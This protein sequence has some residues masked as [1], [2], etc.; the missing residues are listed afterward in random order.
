MA[1]FVITIP[2]AVVTRIRL[3]FGSNDPESGVRV[4]ATTIEVRAVLKNYLK[5]HVIEYE[6]GEAAKVKR[7][8]VGGETW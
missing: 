1:D 2:D 7:E 5:S 3:A 8:S 4:P 6:T